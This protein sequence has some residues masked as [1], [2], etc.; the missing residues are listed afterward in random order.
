MGALVEGSPAFFDADADV[1]SSD[2]SGNPND[3]EREERVSL[4]A[5]S[6]LALDSSASLACRRVTGA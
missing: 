5:P 6:P 2:A 4:L 1:D 3:N